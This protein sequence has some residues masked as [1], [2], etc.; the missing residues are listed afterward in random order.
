[1]SSKKNIVKRDSQT[2]QKLK[3]GTTYDRIYA[4]YI[5]PEQVELTDKEEEQRERWT[6][7]WTTLLNER[8]TGTVVEMMCS[9]YDISPAQAYR[10]LK[11]AKKLFG[12]VNESTKQAERNFLSELALQTFHEAAQAGNYNQMNKAIANLIKLKQLDQE[13]PDN[14]DEDSMKSH[15]YYMVVTVNNQNIKLDFN[16]LDT[17]S[18]DNKRKLA[19]ILEKDIDDVEAAEIMES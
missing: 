2:I 19:E 4:H 5:Y 7:A 14:Y 18:R 11:S 12:D 1:M 8:T 16:E 15:N 6:F 3:N 13:D 17:M 9:Q 10:D